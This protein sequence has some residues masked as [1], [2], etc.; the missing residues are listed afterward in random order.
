[1][2]FQDPFPLKASDHTLGGTGH[3]SRVGSALG[4]VNTSIPSM[5]SPTDC[6]SSQ[7]SHTQHHSIGNHSIL[8][9]IIHNFVNK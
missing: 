1:M 7:T 2:S 6:H 4:M 3:G 5:T 8:F 9:H